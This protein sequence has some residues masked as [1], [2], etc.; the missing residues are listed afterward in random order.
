VAK[1]SIVDR[2]KCVTSKSNLVIERRLF[3]SLS[4]FDNKIN[5]VTL[6]VRDVTVQETESTSSAKCGSSFTVVTI[7][8]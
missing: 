4:R 3:F 8:F 5:S 6:T 7:S 2:D 1:L